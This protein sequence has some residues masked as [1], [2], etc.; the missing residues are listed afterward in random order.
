MPTTLYAYANY[1]VALEYNNPGYIERNPGYLTIPKVSQSNRRTLFLTFA[2]PFPQTFKKLT[3]AKLYIWVESPTGT[4]QLTD[5]NVSALKTKIDLQASGFSYP[6]RDVFPW[7]SQWAHFDTRTTAVGSFISTVSYSNLTEWELAVKGLTNGVGIYPDNYSFD[8][9]YVYGANTSQAFK[10]YFALQYSDTDIDIAANEI[11]PAGGFVDDRRATNFTWG[12]TVNDFTLFEPEFVAACQFSLEWR[13]SAGATT[14]SITG[15][16]S[17]CTVPANTFPTTGTF[18]ARLAIRTPSSNYVYSSWRD[19]TTTEPTSTAIPVSPS[20]GIESDA[21]PVQFTWRHVTAAGTAQTGAQLQ[22]STNQSTWNTLATINDDAQTASIS[23]SGKPAGTLYW[24][25]RTKNGDGTYGEWSAPASFVFVAAPPTPVISVN[26]LPLTVV[27]WQAEEQQ[28]YRVYIDGVDYGV[29]FGNASS[30]TVPNPIPDGE[31]VARVLVQGGLGL[32]SSPA[33]AAFN[34]TNVPGDDIQITAQDGIDTQITW[35]QVSNVMFYIVYRDGKPIGKTAANVFTDRYAAGEHEYYVEAILN[36][37]NYSK[38]ATANARSGNG[39]TVICDVNNDEWLELLLTDSGDNQQ[40]FNYS[41]QIT[42]RHVTGAEYPIIE[43]SEYIDRY[44]SYAV[45]FKCKH[46]AARF[47]ALRGKV[48]ILK[49]RA[50]ELTIGA[51]TALEKTVGNFYMTYSFSIQRIYW[52]DF[53]DDTN[54]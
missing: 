21:A 6:A 5:I 15:T 52:E 12:Y 43:M 3:E 7:G 32:W 22:W 39:K 18:Q 19:F 25:V 17:G 24:R 53:I 38:S 10:P 1:G 31:H 48:V 50:D 46:E 26:P 11:A 14:H 41:K 2:K 13:T 29:R 45:A 34:V 20:D 42:S 35:S 16:K 47:E 44:S 8:P 40:R 4:R 49:S 9:Y 27:N 51:I 23:L 28:A 33:S 30:F 37:G 36:N 54:S